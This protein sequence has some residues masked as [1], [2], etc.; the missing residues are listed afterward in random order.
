MIS[1]NAIW[2]F[3]LIGILGI[4][5]ILLTMLILN[6][7]IRGKDFSLLNNFPFEFLKI[8]PNI[9]Y[10]FKLLM[11]ILTGL[12]FSP[13][14][15]ITPLLPDFGDLGFLSILITCVFGLAGIANC[16]LFFFDAR[17]TKTHMILVTVAMSLTF[18]ANALAT[19]LSI[20]VYKTYLDMADSHPASIVLAIVSGII[21]IGIL[22]LIFN[23]KLTSW[24]KLHSETTQSGEKIYT[25]PKVF[26]LALSEWI[27]IFLNI[28]GELLF[29]LSLIK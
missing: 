2:L 13:L 8:N 4:A 19:L 24:A 12:A 5:I 26:I 23:P 16:L 18:L 28:I 15:V 27:I 9:A 3:S 20:L 6:S 7:N 10:T 22:A 25:R 11:F 21:A 29:V 1:V 17:F 14:F